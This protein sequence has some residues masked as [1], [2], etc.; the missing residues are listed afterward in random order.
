MKKS[1]SVL[2]LL[3]AL[4]VSGVCSAAE[5]LPASV[6]PVP[7]TKQFEWMSVSTWYQKHAADVVVA[8]AG[9]SR[10]VFLGDSITDGWDGTEI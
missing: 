6:K 3:I 10:V 5:P 7:R 1:A 9:D 8:E 2:T 4:V